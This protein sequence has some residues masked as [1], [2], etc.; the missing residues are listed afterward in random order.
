MKITPDRFRAIALVALVAM[1]GIVVTGGAVRVTGSGLGCS[2]WPNCEP[3]QVVPKLG[4]HQWIEYGNRLV[5]VVVVIVSLLAVIAALLRTPR[6]R[7]LTWLSA[8]LVGGVLGQ[9]VLGGITV[10]YD[11]KPPLVMA[12]F[13]LSMVLVLDAAVLHWRSGQVD[14]VRRRVVRREVRVL[15]SAVV[16]VAAGVLVL[17]TIVTGTGPHSGDEKHAARFG[18][19][20]RNVTQ[21][22]SDAVMLIVGLTLALGLLIAATG[23]WGSMRRHYT[24]IVAVMLA[25]VTVG[26]TQYALHLPAALVEVHILGATLFWLAAVRLDLATRMPASLVSQPA[27]SPSATAVDATV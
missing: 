15:T 21:A 17:G 4:Y 1:C 20:L 12:H 27:F 23:A 18:F 11:L 2:D 16:A 6:R 7:D 14:G 3:G 25:Q 5:S 26:F 22:H 8:G 9:V 10:Y 24:A 13:L 19:D